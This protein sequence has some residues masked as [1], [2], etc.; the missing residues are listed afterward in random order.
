[1]SRS[2]RAWQ[3]RLT[4]DEDKTVVRLAAKHGV[5]K[6]DVVRRALRLLARIEKLSEEGHRLV[7]ERGA[8]SDEREAVEVWLL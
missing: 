7:V 1:M 5:S 4:T 2:S 6:N 3:L 8:H